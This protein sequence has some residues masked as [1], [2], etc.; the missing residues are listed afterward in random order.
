[1]LLCCATLFFCGVPAVVSMYSHLL[2]LHA[3]HA[4][5]ARLCWLIPVLP[6][7]FQTPSAEENMNYCTQVLWNFTSVVPPL[8]L[9]ISEMFLQ[10][11][12]SPSVVNS[13]TGHRDTRLSVS[14]LL[15]SEQKPNPELRSWD[16]WKHRSGDDSS[17]ISAAL[18]V[19]SGENVQ[20]RT[21]QHPQIQL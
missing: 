7:T 10:L 16:V 11:V 3:L 21:R 4:L 5:R 8:L 13:M 20:R 12:L 2:C 19:R 1:M 15:T 6:Q 14:Q 9:L 17:N 18:K